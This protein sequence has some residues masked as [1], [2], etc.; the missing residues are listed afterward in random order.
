MIENFEIK[1]AKHL[2]KDNFE[3]LEK[4]RDDVDLAKPV[5]VNT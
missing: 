2:Q 3:R 5:P 4:R 1:F